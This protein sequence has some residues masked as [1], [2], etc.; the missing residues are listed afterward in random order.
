MIRSG[1]RFA[2]CGLY[3]GETLRNAAGE[4]AFGAICVVS[5]GGGGPGNRR[6]DF[7]E[8]VRPFGML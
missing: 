6:L 4:L 8:C 1:A 7:S 5:R 2:L 3:L